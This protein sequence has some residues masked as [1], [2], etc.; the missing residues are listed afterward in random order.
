M[1]SPSRESENQKG[2]NHDL[3]LTK[4]SKP[5]PDNNQPT[6]PKIKNPSDSQILQAADKFKVPPDE[7]EDYRVLLEKY[8]SAKLPNDY[9]E[10]SDGQY[11]R[12]S[13]GQ[14]TNQHP[15]HNVYQKLVDK[16]RRKLLRKK[17]KKE[18]L[19]NINQVREMVADP[20]KGILKGKVY[21]GSRIEPNFRQDGVNLDLGQAELPAG[22]EGQHVK[23]AS[24]SS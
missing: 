19:A 17:L 1:E 11:L 3:D 10:I 21:R 18:K 2:A 24:P 15:Y 6:S 9:L 7:L 12:V 13:T 4:N 20:P 22:Q 8:L 16:K 14:V 5:A 23:G